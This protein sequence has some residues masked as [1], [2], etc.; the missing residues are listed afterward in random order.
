MNSSS[1]H[2]RHQIDQ[3]VGEY[4]LR[5]DIANYFGGQIFFDRLTR[6]EFNRTI[7]A[8]IVPDRSA[9]ILGLTGK[10]WTFPATGPVILRHVLVA[11]TST[12]S[13]DTILVDLAG[14]VSPPL[15]FPGGGPPISF[16]ADLPVMPGVPIVVA[17]TNTA[18]ALSLMGTG[19]LVME[20]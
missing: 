13:S 11:T 5:Q 2:E 7:S 4:Q 3:A 9:T 17:C 6:S 8:R 19:V 16:E 20:S 1:E 14:A 10:V 18:V 12:S 15:Q